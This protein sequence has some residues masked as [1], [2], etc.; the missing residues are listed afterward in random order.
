M[1]QYYKI[2]N[3][4]KGRYIHPHEF[5][6]AKLLEFS[7]NG[8]L[9]LLAHL[10]SNEWSGNHIVIA[11]DYDDDHPEWTNIIKDAVGEPKPAGPGVYVLGLVLLPPFLL[12]LSA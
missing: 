11:G 12:T 6:G 8:I 7:A 3:L 1:G 9:A 2:V 5:G 10:L 4:T